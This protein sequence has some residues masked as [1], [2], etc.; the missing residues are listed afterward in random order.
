MHSSV[1]SWTVTNYALIKCH[2]QHSVVKRD[3]IRAIAI[4]LTWGQPI[5][6][7]SILER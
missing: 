6:A 1:R 4:G 5:I 7:A 2:T 3:L